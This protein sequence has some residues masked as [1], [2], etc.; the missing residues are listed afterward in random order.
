MGVNI[1]MI[2]ILLIIILSITIIVLIL[3]NYSRKVAIKG[4][5]IAEKNENKFK[6]YYSLTNRWIIN[7]N[8][9]KGIADYLEKNNINN[10]AIY[11]IGELGTRLYEEIK[12]SQINVFCFIDNN[13][14]K[15]EYENIKI[16]NSQEVG[17]LV[18][19]DIII[20]TP[21]YD[22]NLI[23]SILLNKNDKL[24]IISLEKLVYKM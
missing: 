12:E 3:T 24:N 23:E 18:D 4:V 2:M 9:N 19:I 16:F 7:K 17:K 10:I 1:I 13:T 6:K 5:Q 21:I 11:G 8:E 15:K 22:Y 20:I 14:N